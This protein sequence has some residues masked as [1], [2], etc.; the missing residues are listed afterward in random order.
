[1]RVPTLPRGTADVYASER[2]CLIVIIALYNC[3]LGKIGEIV[4]ILQ[5]F[6]NL[7]WRGKMTLGNEVLKMPLSGQTSM[8]S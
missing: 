5:K 3:F 7:K 6:M 4:Q 8:S 2:T 1:M